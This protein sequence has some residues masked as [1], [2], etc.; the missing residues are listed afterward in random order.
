MASVFVSYR[1]K[2]APGHSGRLYDRLEVAFGAAEVFRDNE[3]L[4]G[5]D[6]FGEVLTG[7]LLECSVVLVVIGPTW[8]SMPDVKRGGRRLDQPEDWIRREVLT[9]LQQGKVVIPVLVNGASLPEEEE[10]PKDIAALRRKNAVELLDSRWNTD[11]ERLVQSIRRTLAGGRQTPPKAPPGGSAHPPATTPNGSSHPPTPRPGKAPWL[12]IL[13][14]AAIAVWA[15]QTIGPDSLK[16]CA[17]LILGL[18]ATGVAAAYL[19][20]HLLTGYVAFKFDSPQ[21]FA[22]RAGGGVGIVV[23]FLGI[24]VWKCPSEGHRLYGSLR[25]LDE[26][27]GKSRTVELAGEGTLGC[28][29]VWEGKKFRFESC[30]PERVSVRYDG[31]L[32]GILEVGPRDSQADLWL[33]TDNDLVIPRDDEACQV[34]PVRGYQGAIAFKGLPVEG[35]RIDVAPCNVV[36][37]NA[38]GR[39]VLDARCQPDLPATAHVNHVALNRDCGAFPL[40]KDAWNRLD[41]CNTGSAGGSGGAGGATG[42]GDNGGVSGSSGNGG[43]GGACRGCGGN[44]GGPPREERCTDSQWKRIQNVMRD[45]HHFE[46]TD[47]VSA[48]HGFAYVS[49]SN[50]AYPVGQPECR[51]P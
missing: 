39:F 11:C 4:D 27:P 41:E 25:V 32:C 17:K 47:V 9:A 30:L 10:L 31:V 38:Y 22:L 33:D 14:L 43:F 37:S 34:R 36:Q 29:P 26:D 23:L 44:G 5:G 15:I 8:L 12:V 6:D 13:V 16:A 18:G 40:K 45:T 24:A 21:G 49:G 19:C 48:R 51:R 7:K 35:W 46:V 28:S 3:G 2:D 1:R 50:T 42:S 20:D